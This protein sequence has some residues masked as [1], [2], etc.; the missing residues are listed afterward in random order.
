MLANRIR[1][2]RLARETPVSRQHLLRLRSGVHE[3][4]RR[5]MV[6]IAR[7]CGDILGRPVMV[8]ELFEL[9]DVQK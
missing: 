1:P 6:E 3:P 2:S 9:S 7:A 4:T 8:A 5:M